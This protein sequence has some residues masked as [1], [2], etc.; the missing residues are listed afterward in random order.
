ML[1]SVVTEEPISCGLLSLSLMPS[2][3]YADSRCMMPQLEYKQA[4]AAFFGYV[5]TTARVFGAAR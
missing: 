2:Q 4:Q 1:I 5:V 3:C